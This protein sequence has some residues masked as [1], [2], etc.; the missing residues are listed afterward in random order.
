MLLSAENITKYFGSDEI[1]ADVTAAVNEGDK[2]GIIGV[3]G[4]GKTTLLNIL[5]GELAPDS[6]T[7][8]RKK[9]LFSGFLRQAHDIIDGKT[10]I[11]SMRGVFSDALAAEQRMKEISKELETAGADKSLLAEYSRLSAVF[12]AADGY[13][14]NVKIRTVLTG[15]GFSEKDEE[16]E[17]SLL[18]GGEKTRL[19]LAR[20]LLSSPELLILDEPTN[21]LDFKT[22]RFLE[23]FLE[24]YKGALLIVSHDRYFLDK[25]VNTIWEIECRRLEVYSGNYT[26]YKSLKIARTEYLAKEY[27]RQQEEIKS[28]KEYIAKNITRASTSGMAKSRQA[29]LDAMV[30]VPP[31]PPSPK[32][33]FFNFKYSTEPAKEVLKAEALTLHT[34]GDSSLPALLENSDFTI[35]RGD[36]IGIVGANGTG[37]STLLRALIGKT[38]YRGELSF[39]K[40]VKI[41]YYD[42]ESSGFN[43]GGTVIEEL[44]RKNR[45]KTELEIR[46]MLGAVLFSGDDIYKTVGSLSG[47]E[48]AKLGLAL[49]ASEEGNFLILDEPTNHLDLQSRESLESALAKFAGTILFVSH[50]RYFLNAIADK[51]A[52]LEDKRISIVDGNYDLASEKPLQQTQN[53]ESS[54]EKIGETPAN[55]GQIRLSTAQASSL[56]TQN[57]LSSAS[58]A[59]TKNKKEARK[60]EAARR[61]ELSETERKIAENEAETAECEKLISENPTDYEALDQACRKLETLKAE[62]EEL[63]EKWLEI[64]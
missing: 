11:E 30:L 34:G 48:K 50:D 8:T 59:E 5:C 57:A 38:G 60:S 16:M 31:P 26:K 63:L 13:N 52:F 10:I 23:S 37:K 17:V 3:N 47:G 61:K 9:G 33:A 49:V 14:I 24:S 43:P 64:G 39:G 15:L 1:F 6:G 2:I 32:K 56:P 27:R 62:H 12:E 40:N 42:Q 29:K 58:A 44:H 54:L 36:R 19:S 20:L 55:S 28:L 21:H 45:F 51:T 7:V 35:F 53:L 41:A 25:T 22:L 4:A 18:S 46:K